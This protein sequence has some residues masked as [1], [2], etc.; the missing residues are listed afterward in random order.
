[1]DDQAMV[2]SEAEYLEVK[3]RTTA[4]IQNE[5][6]QYL[7]PLGIAPEYFA[8]A[9]MTALSKTPTLAR[10]KP[11][12]FAMALLKCA[13]RGLMP[14]GESAVL[15]PFKKDV[16]LIVMY[17]GMAD[18]I[19]RN[20]PG[21]GIECSTV[22]TWEDYSVTKGADAKITHVPRP[23]PVNLD[24]DAYR[25]WRNIVGA[26][27]IIQL[28]PT[29]P[30]AIPVK[31]QHWMFRRDIERHRAYSRGWKTSSSPWQTNPHK[32]CE[33]TVLRQAF[34]KLPSR[35]Q[36]FAHLRLSDLDDFSHPVAK[37][38]TQPA[39]PVRPPPKLLI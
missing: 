22:W 38:P 35:S 2:L 27:C 15:I 36:L 19:R 6:V 1:M 17:G 34:G 12:S 32:M 23:M 11:E 29:V 3:E 24:D 26:Y 18:I 37:V 14:D 13:Q 16:Q 8:Q 39:I 30:G 9:T 10:A 31:E 5:A 33:K 7:A 21:V 28:P 4:L 25:D 20:M